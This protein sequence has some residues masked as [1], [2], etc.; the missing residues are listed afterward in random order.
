MKREITIF[1]NF[2]PKWHILIPITL[3]KWLGFGESI[4]EANRSAGGMKAKILNRVA[5]NVTM[6]SPKNMAENFN[7]GSFD[8]QLQ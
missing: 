2:V 4:D 7:K 8:K 3:L 1:V 6:L 5:K